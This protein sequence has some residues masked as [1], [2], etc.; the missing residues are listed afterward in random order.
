M[1]YIIYKALG[2]CFF[3]PIQSP[4]KIKIADLSGRHIFKKSGWRQCTFVIKCFSDL[5]AKGRH[6]FSYSSKRSSRRTLNWLARIFYC[7]L[8]SRI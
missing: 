6:H 3:G 1:F 5:Y 4:V 7:L 2:A 8:L